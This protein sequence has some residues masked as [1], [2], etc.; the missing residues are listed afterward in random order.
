MGLTLRGI[1]LSVKIHYFFWLSL[2]SIIKIRRRV[3]M[4]SS[5]FVAGVFCRRAFSVNSSSS[6]AETS[7]S[8]IFFEDANISLSLVKKSTGESPPYGDHLPV[9]VFSDR[10]VAG[11]R[12]P[13][14]SSAS[15]LLCHESAIK[16]GVV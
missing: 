6:L 15:D 3:L 2:Y 12:T 1:P 5:S 11:G 4:R 7:Q 13:R 9:R 14:R 16:L 10:G 8:R